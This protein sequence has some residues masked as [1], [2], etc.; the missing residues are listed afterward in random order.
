MASSCSPDCHLAIRKQDSD[1]KSTTPFH[2]DDSGVFEAVILQ[3]LALLGL[4]SLEERLNDSLQHHWTG[5]CV[6]VIFH[7]ACTRH[8]Y[9]LTKQSQIG[10]ETALFHRATCQQME[11]I[12]SAHIECNNCECFQEWSTASRLK[13]SGMGFFEDGSPPNPIATQVLLQD[14]CSHTRKITR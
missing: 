13:Q 5:I 2:K 10:R 3:K 7:H 9:K 6:R 12:G 4:Q 8:E 1:W 11:Q 14:W